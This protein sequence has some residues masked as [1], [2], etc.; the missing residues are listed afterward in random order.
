MGSE[1]MSRQLMSEWLGVE[2]PPI[3]C[4]KCSEGESKGE[5]EFIWDKK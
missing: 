5:T 4:Q 1:A 2:N 3:W